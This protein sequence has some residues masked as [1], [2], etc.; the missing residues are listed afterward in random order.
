MHLLQLRYSGKTEKYMHMK[1]LLPHDFIPIKN[2]YDEFN[3]VSIATCRES[4]KTGK[5]SAALV[6]SQVVN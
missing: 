6:L 5:V 3:S 1:Q 2:L 4:T